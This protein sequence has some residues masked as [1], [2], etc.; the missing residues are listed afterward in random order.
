M[1]GYKVN[2]KAIT[3]SHPTTGVR[4]VVNRDQIRVVDPDIAWDNV[5]PRPRRM[6]ARP[7]ERP[8]ERRED[9]RP[10][11]PPLPRLRL[12]RQLDADQSD[13]VSGYNLRKRPR[14]TAEEIAVIQN[15][16]QWLTYSC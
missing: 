11:P 10:S 7:P 15:F 9:H 1:Y 12:K 2:G 5:H 8:R 14:W 16:L 4:Q 6:Q 3:I 13:P